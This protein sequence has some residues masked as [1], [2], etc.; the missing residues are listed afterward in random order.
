[1]SLPA[2][3]ILPLLDSSWWTVNYLNPP[4][5]VNAN[6]DGYPQIMPM[7]MLYFIDESGQYRQWQST[8]VLDP[9]ATDQQANYIQELMNEAAY[10]LSNLGCVGSITNVKPQSFQVFPIYYK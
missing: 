5:T 1:M 7:T 9:F 10:E 3:Q 2:D 6:D 4:D 8:G